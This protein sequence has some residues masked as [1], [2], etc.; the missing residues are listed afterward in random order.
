MPSQIQGY[1]DT[2]GAAANGNM[3]PY[4]WPSQQQQQQKR[5][6]ASPPTVTQHG[7]PYYG[8]PVAPAASYDS[9]H[10]PYPQRSSTDTNQGTDSQPEEAH[11][12]SVQNYSNYSSGTNPEAPSSQERVGPS[13]SPSGNSNSYDQLQQPQDFTRPP[14]ANSST[15]ASS[16]MQSHSMETVASTENKPSPPS[17]PPTYG[18]A[19]PYTFFVNQ[20][21][22]PQY[23]WTPY[24][25]GPYPPPPPPHARRSLAQEYSAATHRSQTSS[26]TTKSKKNI[27]KGKIERVRTMSPSQLESCRRDEVA[28]MGCTCKKSKC[29][30][31]YC[32]CFGASVVCGPNCRCLVC[33]NTPDHEAERKEA[34]RGILSRNP[35]AFD[36]KFKKTSTGGTS[37]DKSGSGTEGGEGTTE[38]VLSHKIGCKCRKSQCTKKYC[39]CFNAGIKCRYDHTYWLCGNRREF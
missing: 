14:E 28:N 34:V 21:P 23:A 19:M 11:Q 24:G 33:F 3:P 36:T 25:P 38:K 35:A 4:S 2:S 20:P 12:G 27:D 37:T 9:H 18:Q 31:L 32:M 15:Y 17:M 29:L 6:Q 26:E 39:E 13:S 10:S 22:Y 8:Y 1:P 7:R 16:T 5:A 30:K